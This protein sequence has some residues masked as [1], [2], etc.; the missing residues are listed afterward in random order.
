MILILMSPRTGSSLVAKMFAI[1][2][3]YTGK[4]RTNKFGYTEYENVDLKNVSKAQWLDYNQNRIKQFGVAMEPSQIHLM[5]VARAVKE[6]PECQWMFKTCCEVYK[7]FLQF[8]PKIILIRRNEESAVKSMADKHGTDDLEGIRII[9]RRRMALMG[10]IEQEYGAVWVDTDQI[11]AGDLSMLQKAFDYCGMDLNEELA[12]D[13][14][15]P[16]MWKH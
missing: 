4:I 16:S 11:I 3:C 6:I 12:R 7:L 5:R 2:G 8:N 13:A 1:H 10:K 9:H 14:T 15:D